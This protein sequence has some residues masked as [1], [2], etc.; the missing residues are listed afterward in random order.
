MFPATPRAR[1]AMWD[2]FEYPETSKVI[3]WG[4]HNSLGL[5]SVFKHAG[6]KTTSNALVMRKAFFEVEYCEFV[7]L[8]LFSATVS[9][10]KYLIISSYQ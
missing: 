2:L 5:L 7:I 4:A 9:A 6:M 8:L 10:A 1:A 3:N